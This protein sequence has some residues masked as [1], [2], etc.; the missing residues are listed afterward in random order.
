YFKEAAEKEDVKYLAKLGYMYFNDLGIKKNYKMAALLYNKATKKGDTSA[1]IELGNMYS[2]GI[3]R[4]GVEEHYTKTLNDYKTSAEN[5]DKDSCYQ[6]G[7]DFFKGTG[8]TNQNYEMARIYFEM[9][10]KK[11]NIDGDFGLGDI[12]FYGLEVN[13]DSKKAFEHYKIAAEGGLQQAQRALGMMYQ[14]GHGVEQD[15]IKSMEWYEKG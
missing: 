2:Q 10:A 11:G 14:N 15:F 1:Q 7:F 5:I 6:R 12:Y 13:K 9:A 4:Q 3:G 8:D